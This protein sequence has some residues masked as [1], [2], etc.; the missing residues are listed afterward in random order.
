MKELHVLISNCFRQVPYFAGR[1]RKIAENQVLLYYTVSCSD[2][3][4]HF[5]SILNYQMSVRIIKN[6]IILAI[7]LNIP[8]FM[9]KTKNGENFG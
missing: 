1:E 8:F 7:Y 5:N 3:T 4:R 9:I 6:Y 2:R